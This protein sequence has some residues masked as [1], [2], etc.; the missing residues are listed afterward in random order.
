MFLELATEAPEHYL[1]V[2]ARSPVADV[3]AQ[4][5]ARVRPLLRQATRTSV[6]LTRRSE[7]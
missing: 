3:A 6:E 5:Q 7:P 2:D 4:I 1:V